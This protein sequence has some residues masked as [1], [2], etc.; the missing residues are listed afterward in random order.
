MG[1]TIKQ[2]LVWQRGTYGILLVASL[3]LGVQTTLA[4][5]SVGANFD[6][7]AIREITGT[8]TT[9]HLRN[10]HSQLE[11]NVIQEDGTVA[12]WLVDW[13]TKND[14]IRRG[15]NVERIRVGDELTITLAPSFRLEHVGYFRSAVLPDGSTI[16]DCGYAAFREALANSETFE[17]EDATGRQ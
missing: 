10:P 11:V 8:V 7:A 13:G 15:V 12:Q 2:R 1:T 9:F 17:C 3:S 16:R 14:L 5:H 4:H 6:A